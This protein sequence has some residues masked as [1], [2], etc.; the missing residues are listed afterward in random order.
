MPINAMGSFVLRE[1]GSNALA[2]NSL[3][4]P[5][6]T[7]SPFASVSWGSA[8]GPCAL[9]LG[10]LRDKPV[11]G[12][13]DADRASNRPTSGAFHVKRRLGPPPGSGHVRGASRI[14][15]ERGARTTYT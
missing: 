14:Q 8:H 11:G 7:F 13:R 5:L 12:T 6:S 15:T 4:F 9:Y 2:P 10:R 3:P 1:P